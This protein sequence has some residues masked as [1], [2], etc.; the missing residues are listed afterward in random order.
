MTETEA[1]EA[2]EALIEW[3]TQRKAMMLA[4]AASASPLWLGLDALLSST[5]PPGTQHTDNNGATHDAADYDTV[6][7]EDFARWFRTIF[8]PDLH[9]CVGDRLIDHALA[10]RLHA[11]RAAAGTATT[12]NTTTSTPSESKSD[13]KK[14]SRQRNIVRQTK[15]P[16]NQ[17]PPPSKI[18]Y[19]KDLLDPADFLEV[20]RSH[21]DFHDSAR[22]EGME[23]YHNAP[24]SSLAF[25]D[26]PSLHCISSESD[27]IPHATG[28]IPAH[29]T[30]PSIYSPFQS[31]DWQQG[32]QGSNESMRI[33]A[34]TGTRTERMTGIHSMLNSLSPLQAIQSKTREQSDS[35]PSSPSFN[36]SNDGSGSDGSANN[37]Q[38][39]ASNVIKSSTNSSNYFSFM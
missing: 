14:A 4:D 23:G 25:N 20:R 21:H 16:P 6:L 26:D 34:A 35:N 38:P 30:T 1:R 8:Y 37:N 5:T 13:Q 12:P 17:H 10:K 19:Q 28:T 11:N 29:P 27:H 9:N 15:T 24:V 39:N 3:L 22:I 32:Q 2:F 33:A 31:L 18:A 36:A 7:F